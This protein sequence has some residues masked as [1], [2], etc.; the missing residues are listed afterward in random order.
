MTTNSTAWGGFD[1]RKPLETA[2]CM[3]WFIAEE[4]RL[5]DRDFRRD[6]L[7]CARTMMRLA[8]QNV[9]TIFDRLVQQASRLRAG[10]RHKRATEA[11]PINE[12]S[13]ATGDGSRR[14]ATCHNVVRRSA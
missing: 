6:A 3:A 9:Q 11:W 12:V 4:H 7:E 14:G 2:D 5:L 10:S 1:V 8:R 13:V